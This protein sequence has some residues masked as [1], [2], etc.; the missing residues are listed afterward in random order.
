MGIVGSYESQRGEIPWICILEVRTDPICGASVIAPKWNIGASHCVSQT[1]D[2]PEQM[3]M[4]CGKHDRSHT[5]QGSQV[6]Q[7]KQSSVPTKIKKLKIVGP[8]LT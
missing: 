8:S 6:G 4:L 2:R 5:E 3:R 1:F 7:V